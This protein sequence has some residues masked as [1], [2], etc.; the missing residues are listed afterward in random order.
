MKRIVVLGGSGFIGYSVVCGLSKSGVNVRCVDIAQPEADLRFDNIEYLIGDIRDKA[1]LSDVFDNTSM[2]M[3][4]VSTSMPNT[5]EIS[6]SKEIENTLKYHDY[7]LSEMYR[8][9]VDTYVFPS[10][11]GAIYGNVSGEFAYESDELHPTTPYGA[12][13]LMTE[14]ILRYYSRKCN[15]SSYIF[16]IG[17]V[18][19]SRKYRKKAQGV[20]DIFIQNV[21]NRQPVTI[22]GNAELAIRD[23]IHLDDVVDA[24]IG[25]VLNSNK[26]TD[27][28]IYNIGTGIGTNLRQL[29][30]IIQSQIGTEIEIIYKEHIASGL[31][32]IVL[33][34]RK[35]YDDFGWK[36]KIS[37]SQG[38]AMTIE[39]KRRMMGL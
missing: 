8:C 26:K 28:S 37:L 36:P 7:I 11:G 38:I 6:L 15:I 4:F 12:G 13:K 24:I 5:A 1:F 30:N 2:V 19:G 39:E 25:T 9:G 29:I 33:S 17:N 3:D 22:W 21:L 18:Y 14:N 32:K 10:S 35:L 34:P 16:R 20:I 27:V 23:Y 31:N